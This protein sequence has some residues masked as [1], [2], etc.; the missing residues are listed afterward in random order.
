MPKFILNFL[1][2]VS[3]VRELVVKNVMLI[4]IPIPIMVGVVKSVVVVVV[5][6]LITKLIILFPEGS[7]ETLPNFSIPTLV[8]SSI[9]SL[10][11]L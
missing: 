10:I 6:E 1:K 2:N 8:S 5:V 4:P 9:I 11:M 3:V 7:A